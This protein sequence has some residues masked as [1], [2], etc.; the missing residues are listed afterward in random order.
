MI[1]FH[2]MGKK[3][4][5]SSRLNMVQ[6]DLNRSVSVPAEKFTKALNKMH[7]PTEELDSG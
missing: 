3:K 2:S 7:T 6:P 4:K 5:L 1:F